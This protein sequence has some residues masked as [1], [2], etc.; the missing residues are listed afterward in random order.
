MNTVASLVDR[1]LRDFLEPPDELWVRTRLTAGVDG[2]TSTWP[3]DLDL[4]SFEERDLLSTGV[5]VEA[6][7]EQAII[8]SLDGTDLTVRRGSRGTK[9]ASHDSGTEVLVSPAFTRSTVFEAVAESIVG[10]HP[11]LFR[12]RAAEETVG[13][14]GLTLLSD[15]ALGVTEVRRISDRCVLGFDD[16]GEWESGRAVGIHASAGTAVWVTFRA[17]FP[18][19]A[20]EAQTL[21]QLGVKDEWGRIVVIGAAAQ[22]ISSKPMSTSWQEF[23]SAQ[24]RTEAYPVETPGRIRD[25]LLNYYEYLI[26]KA[27]AS[28]L[29]QHPSTVVYT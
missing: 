22:L 7:S 21:A 23:V 13:E 29:H 16:L 2:E 24:L 14:G 8:T 1:T 9:A 28:L 3:I 6:G 25:S 18:Y 27:S 15:D 20:S 4:L 10:L 17:R 26:G 5:L 12:S 19:P 11:P